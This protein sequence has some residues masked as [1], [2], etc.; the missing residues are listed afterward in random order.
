MLIFTYN[1]QKHKLWVKVCKLN[2]KVV[3]ICFKTFSVLVF[4]IYCRKKVSKKIFQIGQNFGHFLKNLR[5]QNTIF[6]CF[7]FSAPPPPLFFRPKKVADYQ[8]NHVD[9]PNYLKSWTKKI[10]RTLWCKF[11]AEFKKIRPPYR[12]YGVGE[13]LHFPSRFKFWWEKSRFENDRGEK[14]PGFPPP[15]EFWFFAWNLGLGLRNFMSWNI[16]S[17]ANFWQI[18]FRPCTFQPL[19]IPFWKMK[20]AKKCKFGQKLHRFQKNWK[21]R[22]NLFFSFGAN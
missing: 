2:P 22:K 16:Y 12:P 1:P 5:K 19:S 3:L 8:N 13:I 14:N 9:H 17:L 10:Y 15:N 7:F 4:G 11:T 20:K 18:F 21:N 6:L